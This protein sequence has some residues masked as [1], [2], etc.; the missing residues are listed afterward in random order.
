MSTTKW[1]DS[2]YEDAKVIAALMGIKITNI[3]FSGFASQGDGACFE[4]LYEYK[5]G[6]TKNIKSYAPEDKELHRIVQELVAVQR[7]AFYRLCASVT[8]MGVYSHE[9]SV[10]IVTEDQTNTIIKCMKDFM[11]WIY[12]RLEKEA[13]MQRESCRQPSARN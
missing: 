7:G 13:Q 1:W 6:C 10:I 8:H 3:Y 4:G 2:V 12:R 11:R 9:N 5:K